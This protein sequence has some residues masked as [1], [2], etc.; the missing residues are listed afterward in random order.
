MAWFN[1]PTLQAG[2]VEGFGTALAYAIHDAA[3]PRRIWKRR[4]SSS[5]SQ[6]KLDKRGARRTPAGRPRRGERS[7]SSSAFALLWQCSAL[8]VA[9]ARRSARLFAPYAAGRRG[10]SGRAAGIA[11][12]GDAFSTGQATA[13]MPELRQ[14]R[15]S[16]PRPG[17]RRIGVPF[18]L[19]SCRLR[20]LGAESPAC[21]PVSLEVSRP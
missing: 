18:S 11:T 17:E 19:I 1:P 14:R 16:F 7:E 10:R 6:R 4:T 21:A 2:C 13:W 3:T 20:S 9:S 12:D 15:S 8:A 5:S